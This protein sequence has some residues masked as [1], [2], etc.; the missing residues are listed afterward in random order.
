LIE[1]N[2]KCKINNENIIGMYLRDDSGF[3]LDY[4]LSTINKQDYKKNSIGVSV[5]YFVVFDVLSGDFFEYAC[6]GLK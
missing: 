6:L 3:Y 5:I 4:F 2:S 1:R